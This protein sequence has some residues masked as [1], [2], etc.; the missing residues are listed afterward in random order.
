MFNRS[1]RVVWLISEVAVNGVNYV[2]TSWSR[3]MGFGVENE[4]GTQNKK[5]PARK[6]QSVILMNVTYV[7]SSTR[8]EERE[9]K[10]ETRSYEV[11]RPGIEPG[12]PV[13][14]VTEQM[15]LKN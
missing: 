2:T 7:E 12:P 6:I 10:K 9:K 14:T 11:P 8:S 13:H 3:D 4:K 1:D 15:L 5:A